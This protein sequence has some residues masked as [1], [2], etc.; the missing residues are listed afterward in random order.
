[1][2]PGKLTLPLL[3]VFNSSSRPAHQIEWLFWITLIMCAVILAIVSGLVIYGLWR[4]RRYPGEETPEQR[5]GRPRFEKAWTIAPFILLAVVFGLTVHI[6]DIGDP[7]SSAPTGLIIVG[8]QWF[9]AAHYVNAGFNT[10]NEVHLPANQDVWTRI[11]T[12]DVIHDFW[13][14]RISRKVDAVPGIH[15]RILLNVDPGIYLGA[16]AEFCGAQHANMRLRVIVSSPADFA[17]WEK[18]QQL[19]AVQPGVPQAVEGQ[20]LFEEKTCVQCHTIR[21][22]GAHGQVGPDLTH[23]ASRQMIA[24]EMLANT[25]QNVYR[26]LRNPQDV[27]PGSHMPNMRLTDSQL[28]P[29]VAYLEGLQ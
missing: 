10:A 15:N 23:F 29:L 4:F 3:P 7:Q 11:E 6:A 28:R 19:P 13:V 1:M 12:A 25:P 5:Y 24:G 14:P 21:G 9:W 8:Q 27:K 2:N 18:N 16:C 22:T 20:N 17:A 26:W